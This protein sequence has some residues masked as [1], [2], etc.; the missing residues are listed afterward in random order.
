MFNDYSKEEDNI[1]MLISNMLNS[2]TQN[3]QKTEKTIC[4]LAEKDFG[5]IL[6]ICN[7]FTQYENQDSNIRYYSLILINILISKDNGKKYNRLSENEREEIRSNCLALLGNQSDLIRQYACM[8]VSSLGQISKTI[9]KNEWPDLIPLLC[10]GCNS[11]ENKF[12]LSAIKTLNM[13]W[14]KF[15]NDRDIFTSK[16]LILMETSLIQIMTSPENNEIA[17]ESIKA[18]KTFMNYISNKFENLDYLKNSLK[19]ILHFCKIS[20]IITIEAVKFGIHCITKITK[21]AYDYMESFIEDLFKFF[22]QICLGKNEELA[23]QSY[24]Y[25]T[26][27]SFEEIERKKNDIKENEKDF[28]NKN[29]IQKYWNLLFFCIKDNIKNYQNNKNNLIENGEYTRYKA[30]FPLLNNVS[31]LCNENTFE[32]LYKYIFTKM[33]EEDPLIINSA[34]YIFTA[35]L[36]T[37]HEYIIVENISKIIPCLCKFFTLNCP[38]LNNTVGECLEKICERFG[39]LFIGDKSFFVKSIYL[40]AQLLLSKNLEKKPK[41]NIC[42]CFCDLCEHIKSSSLQHLGLISPYLNNLFFILDTLA[43]LPNS[44]EYNSNLSYYCFL[45]I[46]KLFLIATEK[47]KLILQDYFQKFFQRLNEA[48]DIS[49]FNNDKE[50]QYKFQE[51]L[52]L[53]LKSYCNEGNNNAKLEPDHIIFFFKIIENFFEIRKEIFE[54]GLLALMG[55]ITI[56][57]KIKTEENENDFIY[58]INN[59]IT[60]IKNTI[61]S[62]KDMESLGAAFISL[63]KIIQ[64]SGNKIENK[65]KEILEIF[66]KI[67]FAKNQNIEILSNI[68][69]IFSDFLIKENNIIWNYIDIGFYLMEKLINICLKEHENFIISH[70]N[71]DNFKI[72][73]NLNDYI[74]EFIEEVL[75][76][77]SSEKKNLK[78]NFKKYIEIIMKYLNLIFDN[79]SFKPQD[80]YILSSINSLIYLIEVDKEKTMN[81]IQSNSL[82]NLYKFA[83]D[84]KNSNIIS[85][86]IVLQ[87]HLNKLNNDS[88]ND[89]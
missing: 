8:V 10:N 80:D 27:I 24:I 61:I 76:K 4:D 1:L 18:Y 77:I 72:Y 31:K 51:Y 42:L 3:K 16:E 67:I 68:L 88:I 6:K 7:K 12:K 34:V 33:S 66:K 28:Y 50:K 14:E 49:N 2:D 74:I 38:I 41:I 19:L 15:P 13:I 89:F 22:G 36:E 40:L 21:I 85:T 81:L 37:I 44:Y 45:T 23:I 64:A 9:N 57:S 32:E 35:I 30:L 78:D 87:D 39:G 70:F 29:Y 59:G 62:Y 73:V 48:K 5:K 53:C 43:Y 56:F 20:N 84:T 11:S 54:T 26:E 82:N 65:V 69:L 60:H 55:L 71:Y 52:C 63:R 79:Q 58:M 75:H 83:D 25:F 47:D 17:L 46:S 86:K